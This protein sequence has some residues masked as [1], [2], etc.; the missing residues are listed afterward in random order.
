MDKVNLDDS[1]KAALVELQE[2]LNLQLKYNK[3]LLAKKMGEIF[4]HLALFVLVIGVSGF[5]MI[6]LSFAFVTWFNQLTG[7]FYGGHLI[8]AGFYLMLALIII[9]FRKQLIFGP[10]RKLFGKVMFSEE[11][12]HIAYEDAFKSMGNLNLRIRKYKKAIKKKED[13]LGKKYESLST[14]LTFAN[15]VQSIVK[16]AYTSFVTTSNI[17]KAAFSIFKKLTK[18]KKKRVKRKKYQPPELEEENYY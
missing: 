3:L 17:A 1:L 12:D 11:D 8:V 6:F 13:K 15:I 14:Q 7:Q 18:G 2:Y 4:S 5:L 9:L 10:I 16:N